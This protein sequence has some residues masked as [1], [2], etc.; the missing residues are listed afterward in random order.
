MRDIEGDT[1]MNDD[2]KYK[3]I[4]IVEQTMARL[5]LTS[6]MAFGAF[7][8]YIQFQSKLISVFSNN[9]I[10]EICSLYNYI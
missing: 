7:N 6:G 2:V 9:I 10:Q 1:V 5:D 4:F 8:Q 3:T